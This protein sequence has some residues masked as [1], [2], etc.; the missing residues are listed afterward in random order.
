MAVYGVTNWGTIWDPGF[1]LTL[2][3]RCDQ[4][5]SDQRRPSDAADATTDADSAAIVA[6]F[7]L[8]SLAGE[9]RVYRDQ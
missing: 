9:K 2:C 8:A 7:P 1:K 5:Y 4:R 6:F 3:D